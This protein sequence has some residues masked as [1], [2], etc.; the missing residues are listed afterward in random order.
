MICCVELEQ[1]A[2]LSLGFQHLTGNMCGKCVD[3]ILSRIVL[4]LHYK[5]IILF[6]VSKNCLY[7]FLRRFREIGT[8]QVIETF[9][10]CR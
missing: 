8:E 5:L 4:G 6:K 3:E 2:I 1:L 9:D 10:D 7:R